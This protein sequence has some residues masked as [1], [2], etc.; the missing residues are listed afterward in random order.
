MDLDFN[1]DLAEK[2]DLWPS[3]R[4]LLGL[5][6]SANICSG[7]Y[8]GNT[9]LIRKALVET[10]RQKNSRGIHFGYPDRDHF[11]RR[12]QP[13][14]PEFT[15]VIYQECIFQIGAMVSFAAHQGIR[16]QY[17]KPHGALYN[18]AMAIPEL[19]HA[20]AKACEAFQLPL[21]LLAGSPL[22]SELKGRSPII[23]EGFADRGYR[24]DGTLIPRSEPNAIL[25]DPVVIFHQVDWLIA[26]LGVQS[27]CLH[28]DTPDAVSLA[29]T[30]RTSLETR[31]TIKPVIAAD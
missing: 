5:I 12:E 10:V 15:K 17:A 13:I 20:V 25:S 24:P 14:T 8:S 1:A 9:E 11:G 3:D 7:F 4:E 18:Q 30:L 22:A 16:F 28:S 31:Y 23:L 26:G 27:I 6:T 29:K 21:M 2:P 19:G